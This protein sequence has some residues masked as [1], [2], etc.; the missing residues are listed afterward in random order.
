MHI[1]LKRLKL[2]ISNIGTFINLLD[3]AGLS[4]QREVQCMKT[5]NEHLNQTISSITNYSHEAQASLLS[6]CREQVSELLT[7]LARE[8]T[9]IIQTNQLKDLEDQTTKCE[10]LQIYNEYIVEDMLPLSQSLG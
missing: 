5:T 9:A 1:K 3:Q 7:N 10:L 4:H 8:A 6:A 2:A